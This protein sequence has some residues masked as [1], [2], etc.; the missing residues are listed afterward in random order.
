MTGRVADTAAVA[1]MGGVAPAMPA[2]KASD[3]ANGRA[4]DRVPAP[5]TPRAVRERVEDMIGSWL[6]IIASS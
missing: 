6:C 3:S 5:R 4:K 1:A 2:A